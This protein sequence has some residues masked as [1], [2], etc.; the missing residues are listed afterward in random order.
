MPERSLSD[1]FDADDRK[2][3]DPEFSLLSAAFADVP[4]LVLLNQGSLAIATAYQDLSDEDDPSA[5]LRMALFLMAAMG[6]RAS[7]AATLTIASGYSSEAL[8]HVRRLLEF[9]SR[10][11]Y[12]A[13]DKS[14]QRAF[15][16]MEGRGKKPASLVGQELWEFLSPSSHADG[17]HLR[18]LSTI[19]PTLKVNLFPERDARDALFALVTAWI[20]F[21]LAAE[22]RRGG[23]LD[24]EAA[25]AMYD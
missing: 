4:E 2:L 7:R 25:S 9:Q 1:E 12:I 13:A 6:F 19:D 21:G 14:G 23:G 8:T 18:W 15:A 22:L 5:P 10:A 24:D 17:D 16:W 3:L 11:E 20:S